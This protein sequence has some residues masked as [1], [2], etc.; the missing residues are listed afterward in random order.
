[1]NDTFNL[2][3]KT[4]FLFVA[5]LIFTSCHNGNTNVST[6]NNTIIYDFPVTQT[7]ESE[8]IDL[9]ILGVNTLLICDTFLIGYKASGYNDFFEIYSI[10]NLQ[11]LGKCLSRGKGP[12]EFLSID[13]DQNF[14]LENG[15]IVLWVS[16]PVLQKWA[17]LNITQSLRTGRTICD[18]IFRIASDYKY[19]QMNDSMVLLQK[20][21]PGNI[22]LSVQN[23][24]TGQTIQE[25]E[26]YKSYI[27]KSIPISL[28]GMGITKHPEKDLFVGNMLYFNQIN[29]FSSDMKT[30]FTLSYQPPID[31]FETAGLLDS[32]FIL[33]YL[34]LRVSSEYIYA[35][36]LNKK[37]GLYPHEEGETE[38]HV[39]N[40]EGA[41]IARIR[42][43]DNIIYFTV[44]EKH[45]YIYGLKGNEELYRYKFEI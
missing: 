35:L 33:Y 18:T 24:H 9:E 22:C 15:N 17:L 37:L 27:P 10:G 1:M 12:N 23:Q 39:F 44:D 42:I 45:R 11:Y 36:Y 20:Y 31:I 7:V 32:D 28:L 16:D 41:P 3:M 30:N 34:S 40:W 4:F 25:Y 43:P 26:F 21:V 6:G 5:F 14:L 13:Y 8:K 19:F 38:I 2:S 29:V